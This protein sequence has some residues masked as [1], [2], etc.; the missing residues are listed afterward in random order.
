MKI[1]GISIFGISRSGDPVEILPT[2]LSAESIQRQIPYYLA[3]DQKNALVKALRAFPE[4]INYYYEPS[5][6]GLLQGDGW[7]KFQVFNFS[8]GDRSL[9]RGVVLSN[10]C[11]IAPENSRDFPP[12]I[13]FAPLITLSSYKTLLEARAVEPQ[14]IESK[15]AAIRNQSITNIFY[16]PAGGGVE[17]EQMVLLEDIHSMP[18]PVFLSEKTKRRLFSLSQVGFY[19]FIFKLSVH[20]CRMHEQI[21]RS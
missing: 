6:D 19:I 15:L 10:T 18:A 11:D 17:E 1:C 3:E 14:R 9:I 12:K 4:N 7:S 21:V 13:V 2:Q 20:F 16:L 8:N 5:E